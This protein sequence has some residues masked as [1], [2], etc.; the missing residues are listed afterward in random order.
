MK[1]LLALLVALLLSGPAWADTPTD[2][3]P[4]ARQGTFALTNARIVTVTNGTIERG[5]LVVQNDRIVALGAD[6]QVPA[7]AEVIDCDGHTIYPGMIDAGTQLGLIEIGS[8]P[9][10]RDL[11]E[12]G[13]LTPHVHALTAINPNS[14]LIP[15]TRVSGVT[16]VLTMPNGGLVPGQGAL[17][18]LHGY[19]P[20]Q[21]QAGPEVMM[22][23]FPTT[24]RR[25]WWDRRSDDD[26]EKEAKRALE[27]LNAAWDR[28]ELYASITEAH[29]NGQTEDRPEYV[30]AMQAMIPVVREE[31]T[32][33]IRV[34]AAKD[35][36]AAIDW[37][38]E[39]G[40][41][42]VVFSGVQEGWRVADQIA[43]A[44]IPCIVG[45]VLA[46]PTRASDRYDK[47][48]ANAGLLKAAGVE[49]AIMSGEAENVR[50]LPYNAGFAAA[51]GL[52]QEAALEAVTM[53]AA[54]I[55]G[56]ADQQGSLEVGKKATLFVAD[57]DPFETKT[58]VAH[59][60]IDGYLIPMESRHTRLY[61]EFLERDPG[62]A[63]HPEATDLPSGDGDGDGDD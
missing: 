30:P 49:I 40:L 39:R 23:Q 27:T 12:L 15:V 31:Q 42:N 28:A 59:V 10:T 57:G 14:V 47:P 38:Q 35:I 1:T 29:A 45:P 60:F 20:M 33:I 50:N 43:A 25:G 3:Q 19:T 18:N 2:G 63:K 24:G 4:K 37:V 13:D 11:D 55:L 26:I 22:L 51:Y 5:T 56:I 44:G 7:G 34:N 8:V 6:V 16:T 41:D 36:V 61:N 21:M 46:T 52:G 48:Y 17:I 54:R 62:I 53:G 32:T 58:Q 9:E